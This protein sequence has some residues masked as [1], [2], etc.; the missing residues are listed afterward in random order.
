M[1]H[2]AQKQI[3]DF[4]ANSLVLI[5]AYLRTWALCLVQ[6]NYTHRLNYHRYLQETNI[7]ASIIL[8]RSLGPSYRHSP[9][10]H[11]PRLLN[12]LVEVYTKTCTSLYNS[13]ETTCV[14]QACSC[15]DG[16]PTWCPGRQHKP[17]RH[18]D[19]NALPP[20]SFLEDIL[21]LNRLLHQDTRGPHPAYGFFFNDKTLTCAGI[22]IN[23]V[24]HIIDVESNTNIAVIARWLDIARRFAYVAI[25]PPSNMA[26]TCSRVVNTHD[27]QCCCYAIERLLASRDVQG[28]L[29]AVGSEHWV[30]CHFVTKPGGSLERAKTPHNLPKN[31]KYIQALAS[32]C[33]S[34]TVVV[35]LSQHFNSFPQPHQTTY[36]PVDRKLEPQYPPVSVSNTVSPIVPIQ[37]YET[38]TV[39]TIGRS[40]APR[41]L[42]PKK[43]Q[44]NTVVPKPTVLPTKTIDFRFRHLIMLPL[45]PISL[46]SLI[47]EALTQFAV[48]LKFSS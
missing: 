17:I 32:R 21:D 11:E 3:E 5:R 34:R 23:T 18:T 12:P 48:P 39:S 43:H 38:S 37:P 28:M 22:H 13:T 6:L 27:Q 25:C 35:C 15:E 30:R 47:Y 8:L 19:P 42:S 44:R 33:K 10:P 40:K 4:R 16:F 24:T 20:T 46:Q 45:N 29:E 9:P 1:S 41:P 7:R 2:F 26:A 36:P 31:I 14:T